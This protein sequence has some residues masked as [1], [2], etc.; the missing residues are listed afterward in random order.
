MT[1]YDLSKTYIKYCEDILTHKIV[2][3]EAVYLACQRFK[4]WFGKDDRYFDS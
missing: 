3:C 4:S 2:S 1:E